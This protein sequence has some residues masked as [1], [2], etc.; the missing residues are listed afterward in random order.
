MHTL[1][2]KESLGNGNESGDFI[3]LYGSQAHFKIGAGV[4]INLIS[5]R[6]LVGLGDHPFAIRKAFQIPK[7]D[8]SVIFLGQDQVT[9]V[10]TEKKLP[11]YGDGSSGRPGS[12]SIP[13]HNYNSSC[14]GGLSNSGLF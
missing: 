4:K 9:V 5:P 10:F 7:P 6:V 1:Y 13:P 11:E 3:P 2:P 8:S 12:G 14:P